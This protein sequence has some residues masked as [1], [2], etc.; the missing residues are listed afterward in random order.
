MLPAIWPVRANVCSLDGRVENNP[1]GE[2]SAAQ[3]PRTHQVIRLELLDESVQVVD[4]VTRV[5]ARRVGA[6]R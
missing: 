4:P 5:L 1:R 3:S 6:L 2:S